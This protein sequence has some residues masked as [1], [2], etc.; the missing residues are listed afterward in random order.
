MHEK[1]RGFVSIFI[2]IRP[3]SSELSVYSRIH[4]YILQQKPSPSTNLKYSVAL[5]LSLASLLRLSRAVSSVSISVSRMHKCIC[6]CD[7]L[8]KCYSVNVTIFSKRYRQIYVRTPRSN[9][10]ST[11]RRL[12]ASRFGARQYYTS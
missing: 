10:T 1:P 5:S 2:V 3:T 7:D 9:R 11:V 12:F 8:Y 4:Q 6:E